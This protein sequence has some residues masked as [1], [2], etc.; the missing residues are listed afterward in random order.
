MVQE[1]V[2]KKIGKIVIWIL[3][4]AWFVVIM[5]FVSGE[6]DQVLCNRIDV[7]LTDT[8]SNRFVTEFEIRTLLEDS[9]MQLQG[10]PLA[11]I[12]TRNLEEWLEKNPYIRNTEVSKDI[13]GRLEINLEQRRPLIR[14]M[15]DGRQGFY[16][17][18]EGKVLPLSD[19]FTPMILLASGNIPY[20]DGKEESE[21]ILREIFEFSNYLEQHEFW[22][23]Q[24][25]QIYVNREGEYELIPRVGAHHILMGSLEQWKKKLSNLELLYRQGLS[26]Y[27]WNS[28]GTINLKYT[29]QVIC[30]KR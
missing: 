21:K 9:D 24:V 13:S 11:G 15:P 8:A 22:S 30:T 16:L 14:I 7:N 19:R 18:M 1:E 25:V 3:I 20:P 26:R 28:Y 10:Y 5:G 17:D 12:H 23:N 29:N 27:G 6:A 4:A 2:M